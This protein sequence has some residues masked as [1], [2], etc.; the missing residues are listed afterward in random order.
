MQSGGKVSRFFKIA[1]RN[2]R[3]R[4]LRKTADLEIFLETPMAIC[5]RPNLPAK[6]RHTKKRQENVSP[7]RNKA[8]STLL[9]FKRFLFLNISNSQALA[10]FGAA[11]A[12]H[13]ASSW[14]GH[15][16]T[17]SMHFLAPAIF[18]PGKHAGTFLLLL[19]CL[20]N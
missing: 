20:S 17:K 4:R 1:A 16:G 18:G 11:S 3:A 2:L 14:R 8:L 10:P 12:N 13:C 5:G 15:A 9:L 6:N 7:T 19:A